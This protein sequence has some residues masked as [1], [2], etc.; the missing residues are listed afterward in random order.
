[1]I[2][3]ERTN[4]GLRVTLR[5]VVT[6]AATC[7][8]HAD[9]RQ[10]L[11]SMNPGFSMLMDYRSAEPIIDTAIEEE[12]KATVPDAL[13]AGMVRI[14]VIG[15]NGVGAVQA[16]RVATESGLGEMFR[17]VNGKNPD[18]VRITEAWVAKGRRLVG[19]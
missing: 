11:T 8:Y 12:F 13:A 19:A 7:A 18:A 17:C 9:L 16:Q 1:M 10:Q 15:A 5:G 14:G 3:L 2:T 4:Y 6:L